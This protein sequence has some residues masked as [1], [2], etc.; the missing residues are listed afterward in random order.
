MLMGLVDQTSVLVVGAEARVHLVVVGGG[1]AVI[2]AEAM[3][4]V[5]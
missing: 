4:V 1:I 3:A 2:G 5:G